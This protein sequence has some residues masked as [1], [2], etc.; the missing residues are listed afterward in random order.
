MENQD[1]NT[2]AKYKDNK[3]EIGADNAVNKSENIDN[4]MPGNAA[5]EVK[6][7]S[8]AGL[9]TTGR[10]DLEQT[11]TVDDQPSDTLLKEA[12]KY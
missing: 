5:T 3:G 2:S 1:K 11:G 10:S 4:D 6:N 8:A 9:G 7:A 12:D